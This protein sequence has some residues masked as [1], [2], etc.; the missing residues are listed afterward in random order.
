M[1][2]IVTTDC[3]GCGMCAEVCPQVFCLEG[4]VSQVVGNADEFADSVT[5]ASAVCPTNAILID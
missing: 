4:G 2:V 3:I 5:E 1:Q